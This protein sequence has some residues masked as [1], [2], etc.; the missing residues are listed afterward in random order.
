[1]STGRYNYVRI[2]TTPAQHIFISLKI[3]SDENLVMFLSARRK[4]Q[5]RSGSKRSERNSSEAIRWTERG[6]PLF[7]LF[8]FIMDLSR[9]KLWSGWYKFCSSMNVMLKMMYCTLLKQLSAKIIFYNS[10]EDQQH[11]H[12]PSSTSTTRRA[13]PQLLYV[14]WNTMHQITHNNVTVTNPTE[15]LRTHFRI[16][17]GQSDEKYS[18][19]KYIMLTNHNHGSNAQP[20]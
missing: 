11:H 4:I 16:P 15:D 1:M 13:F 19:L 12:E 8:L 5:N 2:H 9:N 3:S 20:P 6:N 18:F 14:V 17:G 10:V 7:N